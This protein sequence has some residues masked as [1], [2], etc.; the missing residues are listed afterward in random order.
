[1]TQPQS[2]T[3]LLRA[4][5]DGDEHAADDLMPQIEH[6]L[7]RLAAKHMRR[8]RQ[9]H[10]LQ[11]TALVNEAYMRLAKQEKTKWQN[12]A[13]FFAIASRI[14][15]RVLLD[16]ARSRQTRKRDGIAVELTL[17]E[18]AAAS[19]VDLDTIIAIDDALLRLEEFDQTKCRIV[20]MRHFG[21]LSVEET[22]EVMGI[23]PITVMRHWRLAKAWLQKE[24]G[25]I[26]ASDK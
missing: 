10:T 18:S 6:E 19:A 2:I 11:T 20:E 13:H 14:M 22:A 5:S 9:D 15:R 1:M 23:A 8:E 12:R 16:Y 7:R 3:E 21:G 17:G 4:W 24:L 25:P 26:A